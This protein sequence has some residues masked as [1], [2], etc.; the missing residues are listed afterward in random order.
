MSSFIGHLT[1][2]VIGNILI[3]AALGYS[4]MHSAAHGIAHVITLLN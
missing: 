2:A 4:F 3:W 1:V